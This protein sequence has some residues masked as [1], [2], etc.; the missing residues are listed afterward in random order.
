MTLSPSDATKLTQRDRQTASAAQPK[1]QCGNCLALDNKSGECPSCERKHEPFDR[2][3]SAVAD[4]GVFSEDQVYAL[5]A[6]IDALRA[7]S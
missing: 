2:A 5:H 6:M 3:K 7:A 1:C 4:T